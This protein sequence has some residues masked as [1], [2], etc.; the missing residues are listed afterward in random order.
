MD[1]ISKFNSEGYP[2]PTCHDALARVVKE[3]RGA[4][5]R[6]L[7]YI[8]SP[9]AGDVERNVRNA[10]RYARFAVDEGAIPLAAHLLFPQFLS[11]ETE[12]DL[13]LFMAKVVLGRCQE[14]WVFGAEI[15]AGME[16]EI[17]YAQRKGKRL[18][19][20]TENLEEV[21]R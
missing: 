1:G 4:V 11:E 17:S 5:F 2:D 10:R 12:R 18:R 8:C 21:T 15:S 14:V 6:P 19:Y 9:Y 3:G 16:D 20:F 7:V 13:A